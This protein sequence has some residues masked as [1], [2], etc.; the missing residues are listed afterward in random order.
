MGNGIVF[1]YE[2]V[3]IEAVV[4]VKKSHKSHYLCTV[5]DVIRSKALTEFAV[6]QTVAAIVYRCE[7][8]AYEVMDNSKS[9]RRH[10]ERDIGK[11]DIIIYYRWTVADFNENILTHHTAREVLSKFGTLVIVEEVLCDTCS[12]RFP[13][14][15]DTH[16]AVV[17]MVAA[18]CNV[19]C[20]MHFNACYLCTAKLHHV[21]DV[22]DVIVLDN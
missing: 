19:D 2:D 15:P 20:S 21:V 11:Q 22:V 13:V 16:S 17:D 7:R 6:H 5:W 4:A 18:H 8:T 14:A 9:L 3:I 10:T 12:L 1:L